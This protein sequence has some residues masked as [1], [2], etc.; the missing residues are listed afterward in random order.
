MSDGLGLALFALL[1][2]PGIFGVW[3]W[4]AFSPSPKLDADER[5][6]RVVVLSLWSY[7][8]L[9]LVAMTGLNHFDPAHLMAAANSLEQA[10]SV[11]T[12]RTVFYASVVAVATG[13]TAAK[14]TEYELAHKI[15][16]RFNLSY[17]AG[18]HS[19]WDSVLHGLAKQKW[20]SIRFN[21]GRQFVG[22][23]QSFS[24]CT[25]ERSLILCPV[26]KIGDDGSVDMW[27]ESHSLWIP[28]FSDI[29]SIRVCGDS[30]EQDHDESATTQSITE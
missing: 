25:D 5:L 4:A 23:I 24:E 27:P 17:K 8:V 6:L 2:V 10:F 22:Y 11:V 20:I 21:D 18:Y 7:G 14:A 13:V 19:H 15:A 3:F 9:G 26:G 30:K 28:D 16:R 1:A 29:S 12:L